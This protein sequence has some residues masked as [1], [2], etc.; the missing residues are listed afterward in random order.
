[1]NNKIAIVITTFLRDELLYKAI[2]SIVDN[3][4]IDYHLIIVDQNN[5]P[6]NLTYKKIFKTK[7]MAN[8]ISYSWI[9]VRYNSGLSYGRNV[10]VQEAFLSGYEYT[11]ISSDSFLVNNSINALEAICF[12]YLFGYDILGLSLDGCICGWEAKLN[13]IEGHSFELDF[14]D[15]DMKNSKQYD[16]RLFDCD[17]VK[18][19]FIAK[20]ESLLKSPWDMDLKLGEHEDFFWRA[21]KKNLRVGWTDLVKAEKMTDRPDDYSVLRRINFNE[22]I[23]KVKK[24]YGIKSWVS[25]KNKENS[26]KD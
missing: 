19:F 22:G 24:K 18:N 3:C 26:K 10:G 15:K 14:I 21:K 20:T 1:M 9:D 4:T 13:L 5:E 17:I 2:Q 11:L 6:D 12:E 23:N 16:F 8:N 7:L 25:Y